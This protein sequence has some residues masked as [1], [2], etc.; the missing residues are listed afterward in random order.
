MNTKKIISSADISNEINETFLFCKETG[1]GLI[2]KDLSSLNTN[3]Y[4]FRN[5]FDLLKGMDYDVLVASGLN[6]VLFENGFIVVSER[7]EKKL[8]MELFHVD[9]E[10]IRT[11]II[12]TKRQIRKYFREEDLT[13]EQEVQTSSQMIL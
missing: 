4:S 12:N 9:D 3:D 1:E 13:V 11:N 6:G 2:K 10:S 8:K 5:V 7:V